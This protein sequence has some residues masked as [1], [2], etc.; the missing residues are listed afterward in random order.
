MRGLCGPDF[1]EVNGQRLRLPSGRSRQAQ[2]NQNRAI[3]SDHVFIAKAADALAKFL[4][5]T[6]T[7]LSTI[8][9]DTKCRPFSS[10]GLIVR[11]NNGAPV[12]S[13]VSGQIAIEAVVMRSLT[14]RLPTGPAWPHSRPPKS[15]KFRRASFLI[16]NGNG[17]DECLI[18]ALRRATRHS[19]GL[20]VRFSSKLCGACIWNPYLN[21]PQALR[22]H[23]LPVVRHPFAIAA[24]PLR[25]RHRT[26]LQC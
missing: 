14:E 4:F 5:G 15:S 24:L 22:S 3:Q 21:P 7:I 12:S 17:V 23:A 8:I 11:R 9:C 18:F 20:T 10:L 26:G 6:V 19:Q 16:Q 2:K 25:N 1:R 13:V